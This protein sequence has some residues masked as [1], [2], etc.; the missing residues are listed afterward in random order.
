MIM[1]LI[2][3]L[4]YS[5]VELDFGTSGLRG[6]VTDMTDLECYI[7]IVGFLSYLK[8]KDGLVDGGAVYFAGDLRQSTPRI[9]KVVAAA[10]RELNLRPINCGFIPTPAVAM[11]ALEND[12]PCIMVTGSHIPSDRNGIKF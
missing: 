2:E 12:A 10:C 1:T 8:Q 3:L 6:L 11:Y 5:P 9:M 4:E 7:N